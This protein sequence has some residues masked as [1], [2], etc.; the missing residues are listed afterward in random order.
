[1]FYLIRYWDAQ[2]GLIAI[3]TAHPEVINKPQK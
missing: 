3:H 1:M 2:M